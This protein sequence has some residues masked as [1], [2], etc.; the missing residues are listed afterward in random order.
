MEQRTIQR[1]GWKPSLPDPRD[2]IADTAELL[3]REEVDP[4]GD[5]PA[6][7][8]QGALGSCTANAVGA[9]IEY[10]NR[11]D[12]KDFG[13]PSRLFIYYGERE[14][15]GSLSQG[16]TGAFGRD[17]FKFAH[18]VGVPP[19]TDWPYDVAKYQEKP[20]AEA[21]ADAAKHKIGDYRAVGR[22]L[23]RF[24]AV[25]S[26]KQTIAFGF[27]VFESFESPQVADTGIMP[28]PA[29]GEK[30]LGGHE[31]LLVGYL[32]DE[33]NY[34]LVRNSWGADWGLGGYFLMPWSILLDTNLSSDFRTIR[35]PMG[36]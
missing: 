35:R 9:A 4:R 25:L 29:Q 11:L 5:M 8:D 36:T 3:I 32:K 28:T 33:P 6:P 18:K 10:E 17:G 14:I 1:Y 2:L 34:G 20:P 27:T 15:E 19:E 12:G 31:V 21:Y 24:K 26:N 16:D 7:Y 23:T 22:S 13:T 30:V